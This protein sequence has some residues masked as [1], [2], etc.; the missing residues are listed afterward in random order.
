MQAQTVSLDSDWFKGTIVGRT[1]ESS[2]RFQRKFKGRIE[3]VWMP[4]NEFFRELSSY[5]WDTTESYEQDHWVLFFGYE[6]SGKSSASMMTWDNIIKLR[7]EFYEEKLEPLNWI[8]NDV[9]L[10][11][12]EYAR[13][14]YNFSKNPGIGLQHPIIVDDAHYIFGKY[15]G[16][17]AETMSLL[18]IARFARSQQVIHILNTQTPQQLFSD[19]WRERVN[20]YVYCFSTK[21]VSSETGRIKSRW[22]YAAF[23]NEETSQWLRE[24]KIIRKPLFWRKILDRHPPDL[25]TRFDVLFPQYTQ[26][27]NQYKTIKKFY[28]EFYQYLRFMGVVKGRH[29]EIIFRLM[30]QIAQAAQLGTGY[31]L[32]EIMHEFLKRVPEPTI[33]KLQEYGVIYSEPDPTGQYKKRYYLDRELHLMAEKYAE[34]ITWRSRILGTAEG[35]GIPAIKFIGGLDEDDDWKDDLDDD[36]KRFKDLPV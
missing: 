13:T 22:M 29:F 32:Q 15:L 28:R 34:V 18:Q 12:S 16:Q 7:N 35:S 1:L 3:D 23:Y 30:A 27:Y 19:I 6:G 11:Q 25:I 4:P 2:N 20:T 31:S 9:V 33:R 21:V 5:I 14:L 24:D 36:D 8:L 10:M 26:L 17:T